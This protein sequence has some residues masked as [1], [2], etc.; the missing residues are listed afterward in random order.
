MNIAQKNPQQ[1]F[2][3][4][5]IR[6]VATYGSAAGQVAVHEVIGH[7]DQYRFFV[8]LEGKTTR[9]VALSWLDGTFMAGDRKSDATREAKLIVE[10]SAALSDRL[11]CAQR[12]T[13]K[14]ADILVRDAQAAWDK[15]VGR[16]C[17]EAA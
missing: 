8:S 17:A 11:D 10:K 2:V 6:T 16:Y 14:G 5:G 3:G 1:V 12:S 7:H 15:F 4:R 13:L 9:V